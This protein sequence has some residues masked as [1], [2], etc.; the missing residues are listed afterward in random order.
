VSFGDLSC[1][2]KLNHPCDL[3]EHQFREL[4]Y[5]YNRART[6]TFDPIF[7]LTSDMPSLSSFADRRAVRVVTTITDGCARESGRSTDNE[8]D[9]ARL[10]KNMEHR[11]S[12]F[13]APGYSLFDNDGALME[14]DCDFIDYPTLEEVAEKLGVT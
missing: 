5:G 2:P 12:E 3:W 7:D 14:S 1:G 10:W 6:S 8:E 11:M 9:Q 13:T 4:Q